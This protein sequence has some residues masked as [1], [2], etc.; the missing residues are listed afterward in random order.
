MKQSNKCHAQ[1]K[2]M[3]LGGRV[4]GGLKQE[5][6]GNADGYINIDGVVTGGFQQTNIGLDGC[7]IDATGNSVSTGGAAEG[8]SSAPNINFDDIGISVKVRNSQNNQPAPGLSATFTDE[9]G[10]AVDENVPVD[11]AGIAFGNVPSNGKY[12]VKI[13]GPGF[14]E[15]TV[16]VTVNCTSQDCH[17]EKLI[18]VSPSIP[19][20][21]TRIIMTWIDKPS[22]IDLHVMAIK[23]SDNS[24]CGTYFGN[25]NGCSQVS[26]DLDN[27]KGG[28][29]GAETITLQDKAV[30]SQYT[31]L[32]AINDYR[33]HPG[34]DATEF[35]NSGARITIQNA[36]QTDNIESH[37]TSVSA[38]VKFYLF[39]CLD[40]QAN[41][42]YVFKKSPQ[43]ILFEP[44]IDNSGWTEMKNSHC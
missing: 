13:S 7:P 42:R 27:T 9:A 6:W 15:N 43:N 10:T 11:D 29:N 20:G 18:A 2:E 36:V 16:D 1:G 30:N 44:K 8:G 17:P 24:L 19:A 38:P 33:L 12:K 28:M 3:N 32:I 34:G 14:Q 23:K 37:P 40:V 21:K 31:Y 25:K 5:N 26:L 4:E 41:G 39:G 35:I 22:D